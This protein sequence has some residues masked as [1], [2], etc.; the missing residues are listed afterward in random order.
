L[1]RWDGSSVFTLKKIDPSRA[2]T[3]PRATYRFQFNEKF[4][5]ADA[6]ALVSYL[7]EL[8]VSHIYASPLFAAAPHSTHGYDVCDFGKLNPEL[9]TEED[10][11]KLV[12][13][14][15]SKKMSLVLDIVPNHMG[16]G[17]PENLWWWDVLTHGEKSQFAKCFDID[18][19]PAEEHLRGKIL[20]PILGDHYKTLLKKGEFQLKR[21]NGKLVLAYHEHRFPLAPRTL[22]K[23]PADEDGLKN[24]N[25]DFAALDALIQ[26]QNYVLEFFGVGDVKLNYRRFF[27]VTSLAAVR[28]E[29][30]RV[31][32]LTHSLVK[33]WCERGWLDGLRVDHPDGLRN[34]KEYLDR[35]R[36]IAPNVWIIVEKILETD[37]LLPATWPVQGTTGYDFLNHV[38]GLFVESSAKKALTDFY[39]EFTGESTDYFSI[40]REKK[41]EVLKNLFI[42]ELNR[43]T[44]VLIKVAGRRDKGRGFSDQQF[45][46][47]LEEIL[48]SFPVY[49]SYI[50]E[51]SSA[52]DADIA[53]IKSAIHLACEA[54]KDLPPEIFAFIHALFLTPQLSVAS[55]NFIARFQQ[56]TG[57]VMAKGIED[58]AFY[59]FNRFTSLNEVGADPKHFGISVEAFHKF[60]QQQKNDWPHSQLTTSTHD[61]KRAEDVRA[62]LNVLSE[63]PGAWPQA[64]RRWAKMNECHR[65]NNFPDRNAEYLFY[66]TLVGAWPISE[67]RA[68]FYMEKSAHESKQHTTWTNRNEAY[69]KALKDFVSETLR[70]PQFTADL[71]HFVGTLAD[72]AAVN[73]LAQTLIKLTAPGVPDIY[74]G[75][76]LW[77]WSTVDPDNRRPVDFI[78]RENLVTELKNHSV[79]KIWTRRAE[80][81]PKLFVI[82]KTLKLRERHGDFADL[83][84]QPIFARGARAENLAAFAR[85]G[86]MITLFPRFTL[87]IKN[88]WQETSLTLP[89]GNWRNEFTGENFSG[90]LRAENI[91][92]RF[93]VALLVKGE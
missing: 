39:A 56:L 90:E 76:E 10:L 48:V 93:P 8:G 4:R 80:G 32:D 57:P 14:L 40:V 13:A 88:D 74:Q 61:T 84:Y 62:R 1:K 3:I 58:T 44:H 67:A 60:L 15:H 6:I 37:E 82:Q 27:A 35:L 52:S 89:E 17:P 81:L 91:F 21:E 63:I 83:D 64:V 73:S 92:Q 43:L 31:F 7:H 20:V 5:L 87:K 29:D 42:S 12:N 45:H 28:V 78:L 26:K 72:A 19:Q 71:E 86:S 66:Q 50:S 11:E 79:E 70:D 36:A 30:Q 38:N 53:V 22:S 75:C 65:Q 47:A 23:L 54:R 69:E 46:D 16:I 49:R 25:S 33:K 77:D 18:W 9:G 24:I 51:K 2:M 59:C 34:P 41:R 85:G 68:Q 55:R